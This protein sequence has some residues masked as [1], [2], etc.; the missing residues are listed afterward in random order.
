MQQWVLDIEEPVGPEQQQGEGEAAPDAPQQASVS[1]A[2]AEGANESAASQQ[3]SE[4]TSGSFQEAGKPDMTPSLAIPC[5][6]AQSC[7]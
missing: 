3:G 1:D 2:H 4:E 7:V 6:A 5:S